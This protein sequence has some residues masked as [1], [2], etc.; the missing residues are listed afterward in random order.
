MRTWVYERTVKILIIVAPIKITIA[1]IKETIW[2]DN[3]VMHP[4]DADRLFNSVPANSQ[5]LVVSL[6]FLKV[7]YDLTPDFS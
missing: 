5:S 2:F 7:K 6:T 4:K 1:V 3:A